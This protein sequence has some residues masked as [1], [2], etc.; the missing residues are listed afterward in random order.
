MHELSFW[1]G[2][3]FDSMLLWGKTPNT[4]MHSLGLRY[5]MQFMRIY[6][7]EV[8]YIFKLSLYS[9][10]SYP[11]FKE[12]RPRNSITGFGIVPVGFQLNFRGDK[13]VQPFLN[14]TGGFMYF[15]QPFPDFRGKRFNFTFAIGGG[16]EFMLSESVSLSLGVRY[17]HLSNGQLGQ[18]NPGIDSSMF[19]SAITIF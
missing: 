2:Y 8:E 14:T 7:A 16:F 18:V 11:E 13:T 15:Q 6:T 5:N 12:G 9:K 10:Y 19:Y 17:H 1:G 3:S 4:T